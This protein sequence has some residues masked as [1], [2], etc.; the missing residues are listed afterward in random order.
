PVR[1]T[2]RH[3]Y[4]RRRRYGGTPMNASTCRLVA[5]PRPPAR[6][7]RLAVPGA[8]WPKV[9]LHLPLRDE[10]PELVRRTLDSLAALDYP[11]FE[12]LV[13]DTHTSD[14][15]RWE[16]VAEHC[17][18]LGPQFRFFHLGPFPGFRA[19]ALNFALRETSLASEVIGVL[20]AG[21]VVRSHW[22][23]CMIP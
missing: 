22:L 7:K 8:G 5:T 19:G 20:K 13:V 23:R 11:E 12:V 4:S 6:G 18:R 17:A 16:A 3:R 2:F 21:H 15:R 1:R 14:P 9:S 10:E